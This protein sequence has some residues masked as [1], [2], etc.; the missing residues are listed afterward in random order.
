MSDSNDLL[1]RHTDYKNAGID[2]GSLHQSPTEQL[3]RWIE[4]A[5]A[6]GQKE[7][8]AM[9]LATVSTDGTPSVRM[10]LLRKVEERGLFF[11]TNYESRKGRE[12]AQNQRA[13][14]CFYLSLL[15]R[16]IRVEGV[17]TRS[18]AE[19]SAAYFHSRP[20]ESQ[21][22]SAASNQSQVIKSRQVVE[23]KVIE[24]EKKFA[25]NLE[26]TLPPFWGG[27]LIKPHY[28]EFWQGREN[29]LHDRILYRQEGRT[30]IKERLS[31]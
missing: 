29:R 12:L 10:V 20:R 31:P 3:K 2:E 27:F 28:F 1:K 4:D 17:V 23:A 9:A 5:A 30:W 26:V 19:E 24:L 14:V 21:L 18:S 25:P 11:F 8:N 6:A 13:S 15:D 22:T 7:P 16:Q